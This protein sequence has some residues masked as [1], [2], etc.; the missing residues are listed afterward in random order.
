MTGIVS[1]GKTTPKVPLEHRIV[2]SRQ[3]FLHGVWN[4]GIGRYQIGFIT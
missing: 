2:L 4:R 3:E 1:D